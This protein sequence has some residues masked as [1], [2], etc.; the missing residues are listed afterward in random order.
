MSRAIEPPTTTETVLAVVDRA[1]LIA[2]PFLVVSVAIWRPAIAG[3]WTLVG[4]A[5]W[6]VAGALIAV[7]VLIGTRCL[8]YRNRRLRTLGRFIDGDARPA[9]S[10]RALL[11]SAGPR[12]V[13]PGTAGR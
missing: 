6:G 8:C 11:S 2:V 1:I 9:P 3:M 13:R 5:T 7:P 10:I 12:R 4:L